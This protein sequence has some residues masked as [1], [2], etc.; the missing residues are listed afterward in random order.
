MYDEYQQYIGKQRGIE[1]DMPVLYLPQL[2]GWSFGLDVKK[3]LGFKLNAVKPKKL[4]AKL[5]E[6]VAS[7][8]VPAL[9]PEQA[10]V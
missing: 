6:I 7:G 9:G 4:E 5:A 10:P 8:Q 3:D 1:F 2:L